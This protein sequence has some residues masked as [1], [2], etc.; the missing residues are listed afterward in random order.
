MNSKLSNLNVMSLI[1]VFFLFFGLGLFVAI[2]FTHSFR[3]Q[4]VNI[5]CGL[6]FMLASFVSYL[7]ARNENKAKNQK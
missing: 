2:I 7:V 3:G 5:I 6:F 4:V 1:S